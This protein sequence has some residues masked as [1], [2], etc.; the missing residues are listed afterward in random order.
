MVIVIYMERHFE[1][2]NP[3]F[4]TTPLYQISGLKVAIY[5]FFPLFSVR[6]FI[7]IGIFIHETKTKYGIKHQLI[8][9]KQQSEIKSARE[10]Q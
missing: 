1:R 9:C 8:A 6:S 2:C 4:H 3:S 7:K 5:P 10:K